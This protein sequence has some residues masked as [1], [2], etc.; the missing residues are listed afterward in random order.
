MDFD[1]RYCGRTFEGVRVQSGSWPAVYPADY[2]RRECE[3]RMFRLGCAADPP[4]ATPTP[5]QGK[6]FETPEVLKGQ[7]GFDFE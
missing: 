4:K 7:R 3:A 6:L 2:E 1:C 5:K